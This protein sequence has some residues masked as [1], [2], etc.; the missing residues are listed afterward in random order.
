M[1]LLSPGSIALTSR[2]P[3]R[4]TLRPGHRCGS[5]RPGAHW[6]CS[7]FTVGYPMAVT[8]RAIPVPRSSLWSCA[9]RKT[10]GGSSTSATNSSPSQGGR[11]NPWSGLYGSRI[12]V[13]KVT[14]VVAWSSTGRWP[15]APTSCCTATKSDRVT[16]SAPGST[17]SGSTRTAR[18]SSTGTCC[19][20]SLRPR[21]TRTG[22]S[23]RATGRYQDAR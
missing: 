19:R 4:L 16:M 18:W 1:A 12:V 9:S 20:S 8:G 13:V 21:P 23:S 15:R 2:L 5:T 3:F 10:A 7:T 14:L 17:S 6:N 22:C 11:P